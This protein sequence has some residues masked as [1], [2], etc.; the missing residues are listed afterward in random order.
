MRKCIASRLAKHCGNVSQMML[1]CKHP[2]AGRNPQVLY[3][4][5]PTSP[6]VVAQ[7]HSIIIFHY[8]QK[9]N[10][11]LEAFPT[12]WLSHLKDLVFCKSKKYAHIVIC[13]STSINLKCA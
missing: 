8:L 3:S 6:C 5:N 4:T 2:I 12:S 9:H 1:S 13:F 7:H 11:P 10:P